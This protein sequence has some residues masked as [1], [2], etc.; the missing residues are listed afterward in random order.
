MKFSNSEKVDILLVSGECRRNATRAIAMY[1]GI[2]S[3]RNQPCRLIFER[4]CTSLRKSGS[5][6]V[7]KR[8][9][10]KTTTSE[11]NTIAVLAAVT[12]N[13]HIST[14]QILR[15]SGI[16]KTSVLRMLHN[17][18]YHPLLHQELHG[19]DYGNRVRFCQWFLHEM[20][21][22]DLFSQK[23]LFTDEATCTNRGKLI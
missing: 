9:V 23:V 11:E 6:D 1:A 8:N 16:S 19:S 4:L 2:Y 18:K 7:T 10:T 20:Y 5:F 17:E 15:G 14:R 3:E 13:P 12:E 21:I 22:D